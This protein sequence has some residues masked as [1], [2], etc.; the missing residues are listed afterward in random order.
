MQLSEQ[1]ESKAKLVILFTNMNT[2]CALE[3]S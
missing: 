3:P 1:E 2:S